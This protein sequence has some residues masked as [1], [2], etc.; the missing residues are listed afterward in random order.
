[1]MV[2]RASSV[3]RLL[4]MSV[5]VAA[6]CGQGDERAMDLDRYCE[7][8]CDKF[9]ECGVA[10]FLG[11]RDRCEVSCL[12]DTSGE[13]DGCMPPDPDGCLGA[14]QAAGCE[15]LM[16]GGFAPPACTCEDDRGAA[17]SRAMQPSS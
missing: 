4:A 10:G 7:A 12:N 14:F 1:M 11:G 9:D 16:S 17:G 8:I 3:A 13:G 5:L 2:Q 6:G 15:E